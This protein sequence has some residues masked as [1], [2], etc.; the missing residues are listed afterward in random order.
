ME[1]LA[2]SRSAEIHQQH[3][4]APQQPE[5]WAKNKVELY[6]NPKY[7]MNVECVII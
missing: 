6:Y 3:T 1:E 5:V 2:D 7:K 4:R